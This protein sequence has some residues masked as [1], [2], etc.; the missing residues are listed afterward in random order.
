MQTLLALDAGLLAERL[1]AGLQRWLAT[2][3]ALAGHHGP[4]GCLPGAL[5]RPLLALVQAHEQWRARRQRALLLQQDEH[6]TASLGF[7]ARNE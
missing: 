7:G 2:L 4:D 5:A 3:A 1:P 6:I